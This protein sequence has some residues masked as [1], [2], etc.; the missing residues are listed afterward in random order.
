VGVIVSGLV[1]TAVAHV[2]GSPFFNITRAK[3]GDDG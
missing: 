2:K 3:Y 1:M